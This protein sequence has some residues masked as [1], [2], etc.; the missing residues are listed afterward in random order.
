MQD[1][2]LETTPEAELKSLIEVTQL[3]TIEGIN[4]QLLSLYWQIGGYLTQ[5]L[6]K[7]GSTQSD[8]DVLSSL[9]KKLTIWFGE[10]YSYSNLTR[11]LQFYQT[12]PNLEPTG[13]VLFQKLSWS[14]FKE[15]LT[16]NQ[17]NQRVVFTQHCI[18]EG[19][20]VE[21]LR[22]RIRNANQGSQEQDEDQEDLHASFEDFPKAKGKTKTKTLSLRQDSD[23]LGLLDLPLSVRE[24]P[25]E[26]I[27]LDRLQQLFLER[28]YGFCFV[29]RQKRVSVHN[30]TFRLDLLFYNRYVHCLVP[31]IF[32]STAF[33]AH[34]SG[35]MKTCLQGL[36]QEQYGDDAAPIGII[37]CLDDLH[38]EIRLF[39]LKGTKV[40][41][42][43]TW[44][45]L[46]AQREIEQ[47]LFEALAIVKESLFK[48]QKAELF[49]EQ[50]KGHGL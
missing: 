5:L 40:Q 31:V 44:A 47:S 49:P 24:S 50:E 21:M 43:E 9:A 26:T 13:E 8:Q 20:S 23:C 16:I 22:L 41:E 17:E 10:N 34:Y 42:L 25:A 35:L 46:P 14:H 3:Q 30:K 48:Q 6:K 29:E 12:Y 32:R 11:M 28:N 7:E 1:L 2:P 36:N 39:T 19:W 4:N 27:T 18:D 37:L 45:Y 15:L 38:L 33:Q